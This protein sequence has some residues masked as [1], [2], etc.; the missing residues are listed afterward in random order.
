M[1]FS[2]IVC[3]TLPAVTCG[4]SR[5]LTMTTEHTLLPTLLPTSDPFPSRLDIHEARAAIPLVSPYASGAQPVEARFG[6]RG[7]EAVKIPARLFELILRVLQEMARGNAVA[8]VPVG[9]ELTTQQAAELLQVSRTHVVKLMEGG[10][11]PCHKVGTHRRV[12]IEELLEYR[13]KTY[14]AQQ[15]AL[16]E[17]TAYDQELGLQ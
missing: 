7:S 3:L 5:L 12:R 13:R 16:D 17:M 10:E 8:L 6:P 11:L 15:K 1:S 9:K 4:S 2:V 14:A